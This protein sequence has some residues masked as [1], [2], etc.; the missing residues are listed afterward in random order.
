MADSEDEAVLP[1][2]A[3]QHLMAPREED[4]QEYKEKLTII[5]SIKVAEMV[6]KIKLLVEGVTTVV[7]HEEQTINLAS[8]FQQLTQNTIPFEIFRKGLVALLK[9]L[10]GEFYREKLTMSEDDI[11]AVFQLVEE[12]GEAKRDNFDHLKDEAAI[13]KQI[14][15]FYEA[16][17][18]KR[19]VKVFTRIFRT[20]SSSWARIPTAFRSI[21]SKTHPFWSL[22]PSRMDC[23]SLPD[24]GKRISSRVLPTLDP[25]RA[26]VS[27]NPHPSKTSPKPNTPRDTTTVRSPPTNEQ[28]TTIWTNNVK[29]Y[30]ESS[31]LRKRTRRSQERTQS[32]TNCGS[33]SSIR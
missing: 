6:K 3:S 10:E 5:L 25:S 29:R 2:S 1:Y 28:T 18:N 24:R 15:K 26:Q 33:C 13:A 9:K 20:L 17:I 11:R 19:M 4:N 14:A 21:R 32:P 16:R 7:D 12:N 8:T 23:F 30:K 27:D 31:G 22:G